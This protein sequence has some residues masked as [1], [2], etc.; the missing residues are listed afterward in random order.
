MRNYTAYIPNQTT[1]PLVSWS[2]W[3]SNWI[4]HTLAAMVTSHVKR[5]LRCKVLFCPM[6]LWHPRQQRFIW[7]SHASPAFPYAKSSTNM[8][9]GLG[10]WWNDNDKGRADLSSR[11]PGVGPRNPCGRQ[12]GTGTGFST[13]TSAFPI[14]YQPQGRNQSHVRVEERSPVISIS[15]DPL[16]F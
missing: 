3:L 10:N 15:F 13:R 1:L 16:T 8:T 2:D 7:R 5:G 11:R 4:S 6:P 9:T 12:S 14:T